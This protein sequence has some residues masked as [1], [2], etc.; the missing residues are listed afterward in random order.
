MSTTRAVLRQIEPG[1]S[2][3][4]K[5]CDSQVRFAARSHAQQVIA[6]VYV[7][8]SWD[9][10]EHYHARCY[11]DAGSPY[12]DP[13]PPAHSAHSARRVPPAPSGEPAPE[14]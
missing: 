9:R 5:W 1:S 10:V 14:S 11:T 8:G 2:A 7:D 12:G 4:C 6:N 13:L 3:M